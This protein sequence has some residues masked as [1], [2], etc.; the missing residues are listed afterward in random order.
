MDWARSSN[1]YNHTFKSSPLQFASKAHEQIGKGKGKGAGMASDPSDAAKSGSTA[2]VESGKKQFSKVKI[3]AVNNRKKD[4]EPE[5]DGIDTSTGC[6]L[7]NPRRRLPVFEKICPEKH[8][9][10]VTI[11]VD[12]EKL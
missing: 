3:E 12:R 7:R 1:N 6:D 8:P 9:V 5:D 11:S 4:W 2:A 10:S